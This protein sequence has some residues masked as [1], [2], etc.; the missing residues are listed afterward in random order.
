M[1]KKISTKQLLETYKQVYPDVT[2]TTCS[3]SSEKDSFS[4]KTAF[5]LALKIGKMTHS[6]PLWGAGGQEEDSHH[7][8]ERV[9]EEPGQDEEGNQGK[10]LR[11]SPSRNL[12]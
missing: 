8:V 9:P 1:A 5:D 4:T 7:Q 6:Y 12:L 11:P 2:S 10:I 3:V